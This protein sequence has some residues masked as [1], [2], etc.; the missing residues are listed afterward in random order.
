RDRLRVVAA[1]REHAVAAEQ[2]E[3]ALAALVDQVCA[4]APAPGL[5]EAERTQDSP[6]LRVQVTVVE[7]HLLAGAGG[8][9]LADAGWSGPVH[10]LSVRERRDR[11]RGVIA[12]RRGGLRADSRAASPGRRKADRRPAQASLQPETNS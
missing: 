10:G 11:P 12:R 4:L 2:V 3:V 7:R 6:H 8:Q 1:D 9:Q 5:L